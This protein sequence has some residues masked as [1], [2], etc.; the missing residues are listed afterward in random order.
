MYSFNARRSEASPNR[1]SLDRHSCRTE[2][3]QRSAKAFKLRI[4]AKS[5][6]IPEGSRTAFRGEAEQHSGMTPNTIRSVS[7][8]GFLI[9]REVFGLA[10]ENRS[11]AQRRQAATSW[12]RGAGKGTAVPFPARH[13]SDPAS[14]SHRPYAPPPRFLRIESPF[15][16]MRWAL[17]TRRSRMPSATV[18]SPICSC[19]RATGSCEVRII[20]RV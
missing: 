11:G 4:P 15:I 2:H 9:V 7:D 6:S 12:K 8:A 1:M 10:K 18:G 20:D 19:Q 17:W 14:V 13:W 3:T 16:S 5:N